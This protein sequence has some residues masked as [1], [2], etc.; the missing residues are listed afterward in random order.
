M[1]GLRRRQ[2]DISNKCC[3]H[4]QGK[5]RNSFPMS[6]GWA[7]V[8]HPRTAGL[9]WGEEQE[10]GLTQKQHLCVINTVCIT[11]RS[12][13]P[14]TLK[15]SSQ[16]PVKQITFLV[17]MVTGKVGSISVIQ[18]EFHFNSDSLE[19]FDLTEQSKKLVLHLKI[20]SKQN[21]VGQKKGDIQKHWNHCNTYSSAGREQQQ[22][23]HPACQFL[24]QELGLFHVLSLHKDFS[25]CF[26]QYLKF[27]FNISF[28]NQKQ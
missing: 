25:L 4:K 21:G 7:G 24:L 6:Q 2:F 19:T 22:L 8:Q 10:R 14:A 16:T 5:A 23:Q 9:Q 11:K 13:K 20:S 1:R 18:K 27:W 28:C 17:R 15:K 26:K 12:P 3:V